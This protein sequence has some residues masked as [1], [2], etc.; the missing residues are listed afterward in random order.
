MRASLGWIHELLGGADAPLLLD[1]RAL[2]DALVMRGLEV[3][4]IENPGAPLRDV[5]VARVT[6]VQPHPNADRLRV[7][8][9]EDGSGVPRQVVCGAPNVE[10]GHS[11]PLIRPGGTL[12]GGGV[13][14]EAKLRG[15]PSQ[16]MLMSAREC[17]FGDEHAGL[18]DL[19]EAPPPGTPL[20]GALG[21]HDTVIEFELTMNRPDCLGM[22][23]LA[24]EAAAVAQVA[25]PAWPHGVEL[26]AGAGAWP[27]EI[28]D[29]ADCPRYTAL[30]VTGV[31]D[32][33]SPE[34]MTRRLEAL[35]Q[36]SL[37][38]LVDITNYVLLE[39]GHPTHAFDAATLR[40]GRI[41]V[42]RARAGDTLVTLDSVTRTLTP[43]DLVIADAERPVALAG[44][45]GGRDT[46]VTAATRDI[47]IESAVF[48]PLVV[49]QA[50]KAHK[51]ASEASRR[52]ER[53]VDPDGARRA[54]VRVA[55]L[56][57]ELAGGTVDGTLTDTQP[58]IAP[59]HVEAS[60]ARI[61]ARLGLTLPR[62]TMLAAIAPFGFAVTGQDDALDVT[63]PTWRVDVAEEADIAEEVGRGVGYDCI[64]TTHSN[65]SGVSASVPADLAARRE[66]REA[67]VGCGFVECLSNA[68]ASPEDATRVSSAPLGAPAGAGTQPVLLSN[69]LGRESS[70]LRA[71]LLPGLLR[72][73]DRNRRLGLQD[74][75]LFEVGKVFR[76]DPAQPLGVDERIEA[77]A[78]LAGHVA[79]EYPGIARDAVSLADIAGVCESLCVRLGVDA[80]EVDC[81]DATG[82][83]AGHAVRVR[84][85]GAVIGE[86]GALDSRPARAFGCEAP[87][88]SLRLDVAALV[89]QRAAVRV[90]H[91]PSRYPAVKRDLALLV[92]HTVP[93]AAVA[94]TI[95]RAGG[96]WLT[97]LALFDIY[98]GQ[99][100]PAGTR[101]LAYALTFQS[102]ETTLADAQVETVVTTVTRTLAAEHGIVL[103]DGGGGTAHSA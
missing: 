14:G 86:Y 100:V 70:A 89:A 9:V 38:R 39:L 60:V 49:R 1:A 98:E 8:Q 99:Q 37:G 101:S 84:V 62:A 87:V 31:T 65:V 10:A 23:G 75:R 58:V 81:Y 29:A 59:R 50:A 15:V 72:A 95:R 83:A 80:P 57:C 74:I 43:R 102:H 91:E 92:P 13:I 54:L 36:R 44:V 20:A 19:G 24:R 97:Q 71:S 46:E 55:Q 34:W 52:F 48:A 103:R 30:R 17:G 6:D 63:V 35:G 26:P 66:L 2:A 25:P 7:C 4:A 5:I 79:P 73:A 18:M 27:V 67:F 69:A 90:Y 76:A 77:V 40:G 96:E 93:A 51:L 41:A 33:P 32:G 94:A 16:G 11:Y 53:G 78:V 82:F 42:R 56:L 21:L 45:M 28:E 64:P 88:F 22:I 68:L 85:G 12:P 3:S 61:N 47:L